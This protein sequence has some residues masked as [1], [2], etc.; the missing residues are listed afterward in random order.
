MTAK[1]PPLSWI[2]GGPA[3]RLAWRRY[4]IRDLLSGMNTL[5]WHHL[6]KLG[7]VDSTSYMGAVLGVVA[8][9]RYRFRATRARANLLKLRP[10]LA[11]LQDKAMLRVWDNIGRVLAEFSVIERIW[12]SASSRV[13][14]TGFEHVEAARAAGRPRIFVGVH[15]G[16]WEL[17]GPKLIDLGENVVEFYEPPPNRFRRAVT[18]YSRRRYAARLL[19]PGTASALK[20][21]R[22]VKEAAASLVIL[23]DETRHRRVQAP[24]LGREIS[25]AGNLGNAVRLAAKTGALLLPAYVLREKGARFRVHVLPPIQASAT[26]DAKADMRADAERLDA[27]LG[28]AV[29]DNLEQWVVLP[30]LKLDGVTSGS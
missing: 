20:A 12:D 21:I 15:L 1:G 25:L 2:W 23:V 14:I 30:V 8:A 24:S 7:S 5:V 28:Q 17:L 19:P 18:E 4:W 27:I 22:Q 6:L 13:G 26:G 3:E 29:L 9:P 11:P 16:N 10:D